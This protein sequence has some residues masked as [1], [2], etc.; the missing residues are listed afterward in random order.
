M[1]FLRLGLSRA[2]GPPLTS[3]EVAPYAE[4]YHAGTSRVGVLLIHGFTGSPLSM[5]AWAEHL[6]ADGFRVAVPRLPGHGT[7]WQELAMTE[8][9]DWYACVERELAR[10]SDDCDQVFVCGLSMGG[11]LA[12]LLAERHPDQITGVVLVNAVITSTDK[13][14]LALPVL[15]RFL[16]SLAGISNDIARPGVDEGAYSRTPLR[17]AYS[18][19]ALWREIRRDLDQV[20]QPLLIF[21]SVQ[22]HVVDPSSARAILATVASRDVSEQLLHRSYHVA[23]MDYEAADIFAQSSAFFR[24]LLPPDGA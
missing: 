11:G 21:R 8:W 2:P 20:H 12:L 9:T 5:R 15:R 4:P 14:A 10:L 13:R 18:M 1:S 24:R 19:T 7:S 22:D 3:A 17:A 6:A 23:T 16:P